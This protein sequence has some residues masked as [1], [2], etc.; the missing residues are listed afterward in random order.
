MFS[1]YG[2]TTYIYTRRQAEE[3]WRTWV[4]K[5]Q[6]PPTREQARPHGRKK[7][8]EKEGEKRKI[9]DAA[10]GACG[11]RLG[12]CGVG[13]SRVVFEHDAVF[14]KLPGGG[15]RVTGDPAGE[16]V[17]QALVDL[18]HR[19]PGP[20]LSSLATP[21]GGSAFGNAFQYFAI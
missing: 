4:S 11:F 14:L 5:V 20:P 2:I 16:A 15:V 19:V 7:T 13:L 10:C 6:G 3:G 17:P 18:Q 12:A 9:R 21:A 8:H 1:Y